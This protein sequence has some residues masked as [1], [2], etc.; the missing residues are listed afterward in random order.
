VTENEIVN[1]LKAGA[2]L[3]DKA[4]AFLFES[5]SY[6]GPII[7]FL[8]SKGLSA[9]ECNILWTDI[10]VKFA[11]LVKKG[12]YVHQNKLGGYLKNLAGYMFLNYIRDNKKYKSD[13]IESTLLK[14][15]YLEASTNNHKE[16]KEL[17]EKQLKILGNTCKAILS[18][19]S[20]DYSM[21]EIMQKMKFVSVEATRKRKHIC[22]K[23]LLDN[24]SSN[25]SLMD[26]FKD[27]YYD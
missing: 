22:L 20:L 14:D 12:K 11:L 9:D 27:Y 10:L 2:L 13:D 17:F 19:W 3:H 4:L 23:K 7:S 21:Q 18:L 25:K 15:E 5:D 26:L 8:R 6:R 16:L 1:N 24:I